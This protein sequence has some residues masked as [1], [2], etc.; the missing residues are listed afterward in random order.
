MQIATCQSLYKTDLIPLQE[1]DIEA[2]C[3]I[4]ELQVSYVGAGGQKNL[5]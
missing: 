5:M 3:G 4:H 1:T 2:L